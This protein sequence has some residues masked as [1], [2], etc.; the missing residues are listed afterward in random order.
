[1]P[2]NNCRAETNAVFR[3][4]FLLLIA[5]I[6]VKERLKVNDMHPIEEEEKIVQ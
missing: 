6:I 1:M 5:Y 3:R 4:K 2:Y